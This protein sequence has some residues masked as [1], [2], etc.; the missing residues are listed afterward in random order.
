MRAEL[1]RTPLGGYLT[2]PHNFLAMTKRSQYQI[3]RPDESEGEGRGVSVPAA[4]KYIS[5]TPSARRAPGTSSRSPSASASWT[6]TS[7]SATIPP[8]P[9]STPPT[10]SAWTIRSSSSPSKPIPRRLPRPRPGTPRD[11]DRRY[12]E[13]IPHLHLRPPH[14]RRNARPP[15][16]RRQGTGVGSRNTIC[17]SFERSNN[18][19]YAR[20]AQTT[21]LAELL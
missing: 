15:R 3:G 20:S 4:Q 18:P 14:P 7:A 2:T 8:R 10:P 9:N 21:P 6:S 17:L 16:I 11:R 1:L 5:S 12:T 13:A 19:R